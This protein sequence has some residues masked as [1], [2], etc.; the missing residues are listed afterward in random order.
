[1]AD[2]QSTVNKHS[3]MAH[4]AAILSCDEYVHTLTSG[5]QWIQRAKMRSRTTWTLGTCRQVRLLGESLGSKSTTGSPASHLCLS[6]CQGVIKSSL[7]KVASKL[8]CRRLCRCWTATF[9]DPRTP[10]LMTS[11]NASTMSSTWCQTPFLAQPRQH[12][13]TRYLTIIGCTCTRD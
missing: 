11:S 9:L 7:R 6:T 13:E 12:G 1:M 4:C 2:L 5:T 10:S 8:Q 3:N